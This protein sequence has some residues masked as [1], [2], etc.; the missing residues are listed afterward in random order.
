LHGTQEESAGAGP[1]CAVEEALGDV[2][3]NIDV[4]VVM[5]VLNEE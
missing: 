5:Y 3:D 2:E 4:A 1:R